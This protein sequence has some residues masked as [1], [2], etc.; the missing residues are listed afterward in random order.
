MSLTVTISRDGE[1]LVLNDYPDDSGFWLPE[2]GITWPSFTMR[3]TYAP[4]S[5]E[6]AGRA[7][8]KAVEDAGQ[9]T[10]I[11]KMNADTASELA[12]LRDELAAATSQ[13][14]YTLTILV[15][16]VGRSWQA[17]AELP[18]WGEFDSGEWKASM[19]TATI[20]IPLNPPSIGTPADEES[21]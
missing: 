4:D 3:R 21:S 18:Q 19:D 6:I 14:T 2:D 20:T 11:V 15:D 1:D 8:L 7:L 5:Q 16:G 10:L 9:T 12:A 13:F 17:E